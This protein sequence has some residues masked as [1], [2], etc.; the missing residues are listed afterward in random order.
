[1]VLIPWWRCPKP[2]SDPHASNEMPLCLMWVCVAGREY[3]GR[4]QQLATKL[5][6]GL[7]CWE[8][9]RVLLDMATRD[10]GDLWQFLCYGLS[11][12]LAELITSKFEEADTQ[13]AQEGSS[14]ARLLHTICNGI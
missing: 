3:V 8:L 11:P 10:V 4:L 1:M 2:E 7:D 14:I 13:L 6:A 5:L 9:R 12:A